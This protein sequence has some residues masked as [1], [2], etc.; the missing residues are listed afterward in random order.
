MLLYWYCVYC[1]VLLCCVLCVVC[2][3]LCVV[4]CV[5]CCVLC[6]VCCVLCVVCCVLCVVSEWY[7]QRLTLIYPQKFVQEWTEKLKKQDYDGLFALFDPNATFK[8]PVVH[9]TYRVRF[10]RF[11]RDLWFNVIHTIQQQHKRYIQ[12]RK[13]IE[14]ILKNVIQVLEQLTYTRWYLETDDKQQDFAL[15]CALEFS[16]KIST[17]NGYLDVQG[18]QSTIN[19]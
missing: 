6:V 4:L 1:I 5:V 2:C 13:D 11:Q 19:Q 18:E 9:Q 12:E 14:K 16:A 8:S 15:G 7:V 3:V 10:E 17:P